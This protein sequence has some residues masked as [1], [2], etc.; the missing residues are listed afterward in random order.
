VPFS[1]PY[2]GARLRWAIAVIG[3]NVNQF[4]DRLNI[5]DASLRQMIKGR[6]FIPDVLG[7]W[8][9]SPAQYHL[10]FPKPLGWREKPIPCDRWGVEEGVPTE[11]HSID[12]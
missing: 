5:D 1:L 3:W 12:S 4:A 10:A 2:Q 8:A 11:P 7:L 6:R 9:E